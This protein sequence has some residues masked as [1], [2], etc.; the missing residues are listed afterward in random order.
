[1]NGKV[2]V[3]KILKVEWHGATQPRCREPPVVVKVFAP[4]L[5]AV[6]SVVATQQSLSRKC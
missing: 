4:L 6:S 5:M 1:M 2:K 3:V